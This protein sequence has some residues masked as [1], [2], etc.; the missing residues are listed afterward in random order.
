MMLS[1]KMV[2]PSDE[3]VAT[4]PALLMQRTVTKILLDE[5]L[6]GNSASAEVCPSFNSLN[7]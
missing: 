1:F 3:L 5:V 4:R 2:T 7:C 6:S